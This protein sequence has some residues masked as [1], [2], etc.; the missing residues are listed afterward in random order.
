[1]GRVIPQFLLA[2]QLIGANGAVAYYVLVFGSAVL[3]L[4]AEFFGVD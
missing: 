1:M 2:E 3:A 4:E